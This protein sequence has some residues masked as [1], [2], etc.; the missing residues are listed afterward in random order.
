MRKGFTLIELS[1]VLVI[2]GLLIGGVLV[3][4]SLISGAKIAS[5]VQQIQQFDAG[6]MAFKSKYNY[7]PGD[8]PAFGGDGDG[9]LESEPTISAVTA[10]ACEIANFWNNLDALQFPGSSVCA[11]P[12]ALPTDSGSGKNVP[13]SKLGPPG[14]FIITA[15]LSTDGRYAD[16]ANIRNYYA[17]L[18]NNE[19][20][21]IAYTYYLFNTTSATNSA[22]KPIELDALDVKLDDGIANAGSVISGGIG[23]YAGYGGIID[24]PTTGLCSSGPSYDITHDSYECMP[25]I[26]IGAM[27]GDPQ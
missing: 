18:G 15:T 20:K 11:A 7:L 3:A 17:I 2:I 25:L 1:I 22:L 19:A 4:Q 9:V 16:T 23:D 6:V 26:R 24:T 27:A 8:A 21:S 14:S 13:Q 5:T 10:F 12:G